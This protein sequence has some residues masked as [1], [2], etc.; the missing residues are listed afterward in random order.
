M[1]TQGTF[2]ILISPSIHRSISVGKTFLLTLAFVKLNIADIGLQTCVWP[3]WHCA[4]SWLHN[5]FVRH[6]THTS[7]AF[8]RL[9]LCSI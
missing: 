1:K 5:L 4:D 2:I 6:N 9:Y 7:S 3:R 8:I